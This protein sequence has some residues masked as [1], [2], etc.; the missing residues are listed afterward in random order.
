MN[1]P[2][3]VVLSLVE[4]T[5]AAIQ[6]Q[7]TH[8]PRTN[9]QHQ[10]QQQNLHQRHKS[11]NT[12][13]HYLISYH[14]IPCKFGLYHQWIKRVLTMT[15]CSQRLLCQRKSFLKAGMYST[16]YKQPLNGKKKST[17]KEKK[18]FSLP[19]PMHQGVW[20]LRKEKEFSLPPSIV[21]EHSL[22]IL[23]PTYIQITSSKYISSYPCPIHV[24]INMLYQIFH[25]EPRARASMAYKRHHPVNANDRLK[26][27]WDVV[28]IA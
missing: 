22:G 16:H 14:K 8:L 27:K 10:Q 13:H 15:L 20:L 18:K 3:S 12:L 17:T 26:A 7:M 5:V 28:K 2:P 11:R 21:E 23:A 19:L 6:K 24:S 9:Q 4:G 25:W 1:V